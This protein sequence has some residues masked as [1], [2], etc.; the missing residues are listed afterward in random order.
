MT[1]FESSYKSLLQGVSQQ[2]P[3]ERQPGQVSAQENMLSDVVTNVR[4]RPGAEY[5]F[6]YP[7][8]GATAHNIKAWYT[9][10]SGSTVHVLLNTTTGIIRVYDPEFNVQAIV[11]NDYLVTSDSSDIQASTIG[12]E[13]FFLNRSVQPSAIG[14]STGT[15]PN[16]KGC[17]YIPAGAFSKTYTVT[18]ATNLG[19]VTGSYTTPTGAGA[20]DA[21][22]STP[23]YIAGAIVTDLQNNGIAGIGASMQITQSYVYILASTGTVTYLTVNS[24]TG[25]GYLIVSK[26][27]YFPSEGYLPEVL[28]SVANG[29]IVRVGDVR[30]PKYYTYNS[31]RTAWL[32]SGDWESP[33][34]ITDMPISLTK[35]NGSWVLVTEDFEGRLA[36][37]ESTNPNPRFCTY[38][39]TGIGA[40]QGRLVL[41]SGP[42][43]LLSASNNPRRFYRST[44][45]TILDSDTIGIGSSANTS[46]S[47]EYCVP[48]QK[49]LLLFSA[50]YQALIP[51][52]NV[53][54]TPRTATVLPTS[55]YS[56]DMTSAPV[57][58]GQ[59]LMY[60][61]PRSAEFFGVLEML[62]SNSVD[63]QYVSHDST[64][65][66]PKYFGGKCRFG[67]S[68]ST[69]GTALFAPSGDTHSLIVHEYLWE[70]EQKIQQSWHHWTFPYPI[71]SAYFA[72]EQI[73]LI[74]VNSGNIL[75][76]GI[77]PR[78]GVLT[79]DTG[80]KPFLDLHSPS[81]ISNHIVPIPDWMLTFDSTIASRLALTV[82]YGALAGERV[83]FSVEGTNLRTVRSYPSGTVSLGIPYTSAISPTQPVVKD[84]NEVVIGTTKTTI[85][86]YVIGTQNSSEYEVLVKD[87]HNPDELASPI[88]TLYW[89]ST[90]LELGRANYAPESLATVPC[91]T[92]AS[93]TTMLIS[94]DGLGELN[95]VS[96]EYVLKFNQKIQRLEGKFR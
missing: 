71:A 50:M 62:P 19:S 14:G 3:R 69:S 35:D 57:P 59:T 48:F 9:D 94:T 31:S 4:R 13:L 49:D 44:I 68:S 78:T 92:N 83:G 70:G 61:T 93:S 12:D 73:I 76:C 41:L 37:D 10:I 45:T 80:R 53:A 17:F 6:D 2:I 25:T 55:S 15:D 21:A 32:E 64:A 16:T 27:A 63:S 26:D 95:V 67:V 66:L 28:P 11:Q 46:A 8:A 72:N 85:L 22:V 56:A 42:Q 47:Y 89:S 7:E 82:R 5:K 96:I 77:D 24:S 54:I 38:P 91:R 39:I 1:V 87:A 88:G 79:F 43:V 60:A 23:D 18:V 34:S 52:G 90:E 29:W 74:F 20:G 40:Y 75:G 81:E 86:R 33:T 51:S 36:G 84:A 30:T 58:L 65:H